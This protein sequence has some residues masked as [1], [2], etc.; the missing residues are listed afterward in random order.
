[1]ELPH[2]TYFVTFRLAG[3]LP[4]NVLYEIQL[5]RKS[6]LESIQKQNRRLT[7]QE[8]Q[9]LKYLQSKRIQ[10][11]LD[12]GI[13]E[14]WLQNAEI[15]K[16]VVDSIHYF[17]GLRYVS[18]AF[19]IMPNHVH[20]LFTPKRSEMARESDSLL[21]PIMHSLKSFISNQANKILNRKSAFWSRE[22]YDHVVRNS[23]QFGRILVYILENPV[24]AGLCSDW[25]EWPWTGCPMAIRESLEQRKG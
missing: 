17:D 18:H 8:I 15:A 14:C 20:W 2:S 19:C 3:A 16:I 10:R 4:Q 25:K 7:E 23:E 11:Y 6:K 22:Y 21:I 12:K 5:E 9:R 13:G 1:M 24:K